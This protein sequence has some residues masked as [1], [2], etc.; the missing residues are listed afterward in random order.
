MR[1]DSIRKRLAGAPLTRRLGPEG[2]F[3]DVVRAIAERQLDP[4]TAVDR[5]L[6]EIAGEEP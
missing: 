1:T 4:Y 2:S 3:E 6:Q 5:V